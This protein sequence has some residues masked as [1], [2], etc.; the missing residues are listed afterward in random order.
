M[1]WNST[2]VSSNTVIYTLEM[3]YTILNTEAV[4]WYVCNEPCARD[5]IRTSCASRLKAAASECQKTENIDLIEI[6]AGCENSFLCI[7]RLLAVET[8]P[9]RIVKKRPGKKQLAYYFPSSLFGKSGLEQLILVLFHHKLIVTAKKQ[10]LESNPNIMN[11]P[12]VIPGKLNIVI[13]F[14]VLSAISICISKIWLKEKMGG[15]FP[16]TVEDDQTQRYNNN[17]LQ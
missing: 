12:L 8:D 4:Q 9:V 2:K 6:L 3:Q 13:L 11:T 7:Q 14:I 15:H 1:Y 5:L 17:D 16:T 10:Q